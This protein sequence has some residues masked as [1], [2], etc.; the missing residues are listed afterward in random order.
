MSRRVERLNE[1]LKRELMDLIRNGVR[2]PRVSGV[3]VTHVQTAP[4]LSQAQVYLTSLTPE[5]ERPAIIDGLEAAV[6]FVRGEL[7][8]RLHIRRS[9]NLEFRWDVSLDHAR[10]IEQLLAEVLPPERDSPG[11]DLDDLDD[12]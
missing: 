6:P 7:S 9:P 10:R 3:T 12:G 8:R 4:D 1:Q 11:P 5:G 2:D